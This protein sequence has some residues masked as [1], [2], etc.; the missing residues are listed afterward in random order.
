MKEQS[1]KVSKPL[2]QEAAKRGET[3]LRKLLADYPTEVLAQADMTR[4]PTQF[5]LSYES[6]R[7]VQGSR[8]ELLQHGFSPEVLDQAEISDEPLGVLRK[9]ILNLLPSNIQTIAANVKDEDFSKFV[10]DYLDIVAAAESQKCA[11]QVLREKSCVLRPDF[12]TVAKASATD[13]LAFMMQDADNFV[14]EELKFAEGRDLS[15]PW[16]RSRVETACRFNDQ[17]FFKKLGRAL[18]APPT[19]T[20]GVKVDRLSLLL[21]RRWMPVTTAAARAPGFCWFTDEALT[22]LCRIILGN[23]SLT[24]DAV[25]KTRQR[26]GLKHAGKPW[27]TRVKLV[28]GEIVFRFKA[29]SGKS[30]EI[31]FEKGLRD[32]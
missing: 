11:E 16:I 13:D 24:L 18:T 23:N 25:R 20:V 5:L 19:K 15:A 3:R 2:L 10:M 7:L 9:D 26:L 21:V 4:N 27:I 30:F 1:F 32:D 8:K 28:R 22:D 17:K 12:N 6:Q 29:G 31:T 14:F